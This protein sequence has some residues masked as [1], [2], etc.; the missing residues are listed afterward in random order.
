MNPGGIELILVQLAEKGGS[1]GTAAV[2]ALIGWRVWKELKPS[3]K[4]WLLLRDREVAA[5]ERNV[6]AR[7]DGNNVAREQMKST[8]GLTTS[9]NR[10]NDNLTTVMNNGFKRI[11]D[12]LMPEDKSKKN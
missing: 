11:T 3:L 6:T 1:W 10:L 2:L 4:S 5:A 7:E 8:E 12:K 9:I